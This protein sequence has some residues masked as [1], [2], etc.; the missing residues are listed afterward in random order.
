MKSLQPSEFLNCLIKFSLVCGIVI[1]FLSVPAAKAD[2][3][4]LLGGGGGGGA[5]AVSSPPGVGQGGN[6]GNTFGQSGSC[7]AAQI[8][9]GC[10][11]AGSGGNGYVG[12][13]DGQN[14][15]IAAGGGGGASLVNS[16]VTDIARDGTAGTTNYGIGG[17]AVNGG[18]SGQDGGAWYVGIG[19][20]NYKYNYGGDG[21]AAG[22]AVLSTSETS[23]DNIFVVGGAGGNA[24]GTLQGGF[25]NYIF[26]GGNGGDAGSS[27]LTVEGNIQVA[28]QVLVIGGAGGDGYIITGGVFGGDGGDASIEVKGRMSADSLTVTSGIEGSTYFDGYGGYAS[29]IAESLTANTISIS[30]TGANVAFN[31]GTL[32]LRISEILDPIT[33]LPIPFTMSLDNTIAG[34]A[35]T[36][37]GDDG[38]YIGMVILS[39]REFLMTS[40]SAGAYIETLQLEG[41]AKFSADLSMDPNDPTVPLIQVGQLAF[42]GAVLNADNWAGL[43]DRPYQNGDIELQALGAT[44]D[45]SSG[46]KD[47]SRSFYGEGS[48]TKVGLGELKLSAA[49]AYTGMTTVYEGTL[50]LGGDLASKQLTMYGGTTFNRGTFNHSLDNGVLNVNGANGLSATYIGELYATNAV[51]NFIL[52]P[53]LSVPLLRVT[54]HAHLSDSV[55]NVGL[56]GDSYLPTGAIL[57]LIEVDDGHTLTVDNLRRGNASVLIGS[58]VSYEIETDITSTID[59]V[60][61]GRGVRLSAVTA[62]VVSGEAKEAAKALSEGWLGGIALALV[63]GDLIAGQGMESATFS[64]ADAPNG[65]RG[66]GAV[67]ASSIRH[68]TGSHVDS[69]GFSL[70]TGLAYGVN[71]SPGRLTLGAFFEYGNGSYDTHNSFNNAADVDGDGDTRY[72]GGGVLARLNFNGSNAGHFYVEAS[73]RAGSIHNEYKNKDLRDAAGR[74]TSYESSTPYYGLHLGTGYVFNLTD[75]TSLDLY[76][77]YFWTRQDGASVRLSTGERLRVEDTDSSRLRVGGRLNFAVS[78][79]VSL[80][81]GAAYEHEFSGEAKAKTNGFSIKAPSL[82]GDTGIG[83]LGIAIKPSETFPM[84]IELG[85]QGYAGQREGFSGSLMI[86]FEF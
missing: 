12:T 85:A 32:D 51:M 62:Q 74:I 84:V 59:N 77:K 79:P 73:G 25:P 69:D 7:T 71:I 39:D 48:L 34:V 40:N 57:T 63:G 60:M 14:Q 1:L 35:T 5:S 53:D 10:Q 75:A 31:V 17:T 56:S 11:S 47:L 58:T 15:I 81:F 4:T 21:G 6:G 36:Q 68:N 43:I 54:G 46:A 86:K 18:E 37:A 26:Y 8:A 44:I 20:S 72:A 23:A 45:V 2:N 61:D 67:S 16:G 27:K 64:T 13:L 80:Y 30:K 41:S 82:R 70:M 28:D 9:Q 29:F 3:I 78:K 33:Q 38:V 19:A 83:E 49:N 42:N 76:G 24:G 65:L 66:F 55:F 22:N 50:T 52:P